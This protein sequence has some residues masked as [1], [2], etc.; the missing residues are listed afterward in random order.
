MKN[1]L[2]FISLITTAV[3]CNAQQSEIP[4]VIPPSPNATSLGKFV[5]LP[6]SLYNGIPQVD[7]PFYTIQ[8]GGLNVPVSLSYHT[9]GIKVA[10]TSS[11]IGMGWALNAGG[12]ITR[13]VMGLNDERGWMTGMKLAPPA[14]PGCVN[15]SSNPNVVSVMND[16]VNGVYDT[17]PDIFYY[18]FNGI[19]GKF[20]FDQNGV[21]QA[22][23]QNKLKI[24]QFN[25]LGYW[26]ITT[27]DGTI[28]KF[29][30]IEYLSNSGTFTY[31]LSPYPSAWYLTEISL[32]ESTQKIT[33]TYTRPIYCYSDAVAE[34]NEEGG[35][36]PYTVSTSTCVTSPVISQ[37]VFPSGKIDFAEGNYRYDI[38]GAK[39]MNKVT[40]SNNDGIIKSFTLNHKYL[41]QSEV[42][43]NDDGLA[44]ATTPASST[45]RLFLTGVTEYDKNNSQSKPPY[46]FEYFT[47]PI[48]GMLPDRINSK[49]TDYWGYYNG[50]NENTT[51]IPLHMSNFFHALIDGG[52]RL[53]VEQYAKV[54]SITKI[55]YPTGGYTQFEFEQNSANQ[56]GYPTN[57]IPF[58]A[59]FMIGGCHVS[60]SP[61]FTIND[62]L[63]GNAV[64]R[65]SVTGQLNNYT[66]AACSGSPTIIP[67]PNDASTFIYF[68][69]I[70]ITDPLNPFAAITH[71]NRLVIPRTLT[72]SSLI[73]LPNGTYKIIAVRGS[74]NTP[75]TD[76]DASFNYPAIVNITGNYY[77]NDIPNKIGGLR[78]KKMT[79]YDPVASR[80]IIR[81]YDYTENGHSSGRTSGG[82]KFN[83]TGGENCPVGATE[84]WSSYSQSPLG[85]QQSAAAGYSKVTVY[86]EELLGTVATNGKTEYFYTNP[87][88][89]YA[90]PPFGYSAY[91]TP[92]GGFG[93][94]L[95][96]CYQENNV[97]DYDPYPFAPAISS[98]WNRG[99]LLR[100][101][102]YKT[103]SSSTDYIKVKEV[104]NTY[105]DDYL[106]QSDIRFNNGTTDIR[107]MR[108]GF[109]HRSN[110][111]NGQGISGIYIQ[112]Y[113][114]PVRFEKLI[115]EEEYTYDPNG[116][117][118]IVQTQDF[119]Y[120]NLAHM[121]LTKNVLHKS[122][123][124]TI[125][126]QNLYPL[127]YTNTTGFIGDM[128]SANIVNK[129]IESVSYLTNASTSAVSILKGKIITY[130]QAPDLGLPDN[131]RIL[132]NRSPLPLSQFKFSN[133]ASVGVLPLVNT[134]SSF[135]MDAG[136]PSVASMIFTYDGLSNITSVAKG[137]DLMHTY[138]WGYHSS[139]PVAEIIG[140]SYADALS[141]S[142][143]NLAILDNPSNDLALQTELNKFRTLSGCFVT[144]Y[145]YKPLV[146]MTSQI[147]PTG[148]TIYYEYDAFN[149]P[150]LIR[151]KDNN[152]LK[153]I[154][155]NY[156][157][158]AENCNIYY[159]TP[160]SGTYTK[161]CSQGYTGS[162]VTYTVP[163]NTYSSS[164]DVPTA[165]AMALA[166]VQANGQA[167]ANANGTCTAIPQ[168]C[169]FSIASGYSSPF[170]TISSSGNT[171]SFT[172]VV[173]PTNSTMTLY[174]TYTV[175]TIST[176][177]RPATTQTMSV[178]TSGRTFLVMIY[179][180]G[181]VTAQ[182]V[183]GSDIPVFYTVSLVGSYN[184]N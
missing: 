173:Y 90:L 61:Q 131:V 86:N 106:G 36:G 168:S 18:N 57:N 112:Y 43:I 12:V 37:I 91:S 105:K 99:L 165:N 19:T 94:G 15:S 41:G 73:T 46:E 44:T 115:K 142:G 149:R 129:P 38:T 29:A 174:S 93:A 169:S 40:I 17:E 47:F 32:P 182:L 77:R 145:T 70:N 53:P 107:A 159:N 84:I 114:I 64:F 167:Y 67:V 126:T 59:N 76:N 42:L 135:S 6:V 116:A 124:N 92:G 164:I 75:L 34:M 30:E 119:S 122:D 23:P 10:E 66:G 181:Q 26:K 117:N 180:S 63:T 3:F 101:I 150:V 154:C 13:S 25:S 108:I 138:F 72:N 140:K 171:A 152:I 8:L 55:K 118:P 2:C 83:H 157:G 11:N 27:E 103:N 146:G 183:Y 147:D 69:I 54:G 89:V 28:Y 128:K 74:G 16:L 133:Q 177:C 158:Q 78:I 71:D 52:E 148:K 153:K 120:D 80:S 33:F 58:A 22:I 7:I 98:D 104:A 125:T 160:Q 121:Q 179:P 176:G 113:F 132:E 134:F 79:T 88:D 31:N 96:L 87:V 24:E 166:D 109:N 50:H 35:R 39:V 60:G 110:C 143:I 20:V 48:D 21:I 137:N 97:P 141:Q 65:I 127:D 95:S 163:A 1:F 14:S 82:A 85:L 139:Y 161:Q 144:T 100:Q 156:A 111:V 130:K 62:N 56:A 178:N 175:A 9:V 102:D 4:V 184:T 155:Y 162:S 151:D 136:Y 68:D 123:G 5:D 49:A 81:T 45:K 51:A 170:N 172:L